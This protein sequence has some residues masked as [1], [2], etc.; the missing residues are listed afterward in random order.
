MVV[1]AFSLGETYW[2]DFELQNDDLEFLYN[3]LLELELPQTTLELVEAL[4]S[5]RIR[6]EKLVFEQKRISGG[7]I[8]QPKNVYTI[9]Q[10]LTFPAFNWQQGQVTAIRPGNNPELGQFQ[11]LQVQ[12]QNGDVRQVAAQLAE[13]VLNQ[14]LQVREDDPSSNREWVLDNYADLLQQA[15]RR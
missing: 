14:P 11:V 12:F 7:D 10:S 3:H 13:H 15:G 5:E 9:G 8:F 6:R 1:V 2:E 4:V